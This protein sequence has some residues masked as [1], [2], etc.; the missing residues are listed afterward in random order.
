[1]GVK[2]NGADILNTFN[3]KEHFDGLFFAKTKKVTELT[4]LET[5][6]P[7]NYNEVTVGD[8]VLL[9]T[10]NSVVA[11]VVVAKKFI[12]GDNFILFYTSEG[13]C[14]FEVNMCGSTFNE[15]IWIDLIQIPTFL[16]AQ[17]I[18]LKS[19]NIAISK[20]GTTPHYVFD[21]VIL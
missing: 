12:C 20:L 4:T 14:A 8:T 16:A 9:N 6:T 2:T 11:A 15:N 5:V 19:A 18:T 17:A 10:H 13:F 7:S 21:D 1:M 3:M